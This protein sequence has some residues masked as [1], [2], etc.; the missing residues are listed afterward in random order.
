MQKWNNS[1]PMLSSS[2]LRTLGGIALGVALGVGGTLAAQKLRP[3][4]PTE[5]ADSKQEREPQQPRRLTMDLLLRGDPA[6][7]RNDAPLTIVEFSDYQCPYCRRFQQQ[8]FPALKREYID[9]G[10]VRFIHKD[11]PLPFHQ[12]AE[13]SAAVARCADRQDAFW[14]VHQ[15]LYDQQSCLECRGPGPIAIAA[16]VDDTALNRC[17]RDPATLE[18]VESNRSEA[19]L[20]DIRATPTFVIGPTISSDR[21]RGLIVEGA[22]P[23]PQFR[24]LIQ[25]ELPDAKGKP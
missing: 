13:A 9:R 14:T 18:A 2:L 21:H 16:G 6:L 15:A 10:L 20:H 7:G 11:L 23:W 19:G 17:L 8:V 3:P 4:A 1:I 25:Q 5:Q 12:Q 24:A 22:L